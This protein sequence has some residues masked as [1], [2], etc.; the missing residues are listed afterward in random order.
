MKPT[1][2]VVL[3]TRD[4][5]GAGTR[6]LD[7]LGY[8]DASSHETVFGRLLVAGTASTSA[9]SGVLADVDG[10]R[11]APRVPLPSS[12]S[13]QTD[14]PPGMLDAADQFHSILYRGAGEEPVLWTDHGG[15][16]RLFHTRANGC[17]VISDDAT[18]LAR[19]SP[20]P[21]RA[22]VASFLANGFMLNNR[23]LFSNVSALPTASLV[24]LTAAGPQPV[25]YWGHRPGHEPEEDDRLLE[26][27][28]WSTVT[29]AVRAHAGNRH[30]LLALSG[31]IDSAILLGILHEAGIPLTTFSFVNG[32]PASHSDAAVAA[33]RSAALGIDHWI[34]RL[35]DARAADLLNTNL[36]CGLTLKGLC[37][38]IDAFSEA[39]ARARGKLSD[40]LFMFGDH[41]FGQ[42]TLRLENDQDMLGGGMA[43]SPE[44]LS[45]FNALFG[46]DDVSMLKAE[47]T[48]AYGDLLASAPAGTPD[49]V[50]D[51]LYFRTSMSDWLLPMRVAAAGTFLPFT[52]PFYDI[53][54]IDSLRRQHFRH[55]LDKRL[56]RRIFRDRLQGV[57]G[58]KS[59][60]QRQS[61]LD[62]GLLL[63][64]DERRV[65]EMV[66]AGGAHIPG[67]A[68]PQDLQNMVTATLRPD[69]QRGATLAGRFRH[70]G[71]DVFREVSR[72]GLVPLHWLQPIKR[73][74]WNTHRVYPDRATL[75]MRALQLGLIF[76]RLD[77][78]RRTAPQETSQPAR[79]SHR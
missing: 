39:A 46:L 43:K 23:T 26:G 8:R 55:R 65:R 12:L 33:R 17:T 52:T 3:E 53:S 66:D 31:G 5:A 6:V 15:M 56:F 45:R 36:L 64:R 9:Q 7:A 20:E 49:D 29:S 30:V 21:D 74:A 63:K 1:L 4:N 32:A 44:I 16:S 71:E 42:R 25:S 24:R 11:G 18:L 78:A 77:E 48:A 58:F 72:R 57:S 2:V 22:M 34:C 41:V 40:P 27:E 73:R 68:G 50:K 14:V 37:F 28:F 19:L 38:E 67:L 59:A 76:G 13:L 61:S 35:D 69:V 10:S 51:W 70:L 79:S 47:L 54:A 75:T 60:R 62:F